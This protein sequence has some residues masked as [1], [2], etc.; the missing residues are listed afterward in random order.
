MNQ[1]ARPPGPGASASSSRLGPTLSVLGLALWVATIAAYLFLR[2]DPAIRGEAVA[3]SDALR[4]ILTFVV[5]GIGIFIAAIVSAFG[6]FLSVSERSHRPG[7]R[8]E[9]GVILGGL[10]IAALALVVFE[11]L[12]LAFIDA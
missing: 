5:A 7:R 11:I 6:L 1:P 4:L 8:A 12:R 9:R 3:R 2:P 10:G